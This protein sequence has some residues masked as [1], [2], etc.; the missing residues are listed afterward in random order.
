MQFKAIIFDLDGTITVPSLN[1]DE[2]KR[3]IGISD[4]SIPVLEA[5]VTMTEQEKKFAESVVLKH[6]RKAAEDSMLNSG[7]TETLDEISRK[8]LKVGIL[9]RNIKEHAEIVA[10]KHNLKFDFIADRFS[11]PVKPDPHGMLH[12]CQAFAIEPE[13]ALAVGDYLFDILSANAAGCVSVLY[14]SHKDAD[15]F[16]IHADHCIDELPQL[17]EIIENGNLN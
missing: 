9:T 6:E 5:M 3:E 15:K 2:I 8:G 4:L 7:A 1:F 17:I 11:G 16:A 12:I 14:K 13:E 10:E